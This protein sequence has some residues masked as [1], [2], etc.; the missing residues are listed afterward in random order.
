MNSSSCCDAAPEQ[1]CNR[2]LGTRR[3]SRARRC[4]CGRCR[5]QRWSYS[6]WGKCRPGRATGP[7]SSSVAVS[8]TLP[9]FRA[10]V[11]AATADLAAHADLAGLTGERLAALLAGRWPSGAPLMR[12]PAGGDAR[13]ADGIPANAFRFDEARARARVGG[14][15]RGPRSCRRPR[16]TRA[17]AVQSGRT[18]QGQS[19]R[20]ADGGGSQHRHTHTPAAAARDPLSVPRSDAEGAGGPRGLLLISYQTS[21]T[22][23]FEFLAAPR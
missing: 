11:A 14:R 5:S 22:D 20:Q 19:S 4:G 9:A 16:M 17:C 7:S 10:F 21:I 23:Q 12:T 3:R 2:K 6:G 15:Q 18:T 8:M 1:N 13:L